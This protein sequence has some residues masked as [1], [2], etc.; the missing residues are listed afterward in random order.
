MK[1]SGIG[2]APTVCFPFVGS[3]VGGSHMSSLLLIEGLLARGVRVEVV[4]ET[5]GALTEL[6]E[7]RAVDYRLLDLDL[8]RASGITR[9]IARMGTAV[10]AMRSFLRDR[11]ISVVHTNDGQIHQRWGL[12]AR[13]VGS[14]WVLHH[15]APHL[16]PAMARLARGSSSLLTVSHYCRAQLPAPLARR[17]VVIDNP[18]DP[19][20]P[21]GLPNTR[22]AVTDLFDADAGTP[23][24]GYI[25][26]LRQPRKRPATF[27]DIAGHLTHDFD[28]RAVFPL[29]GPIRT[30]LAA[31][32]DQRR[33]KWAIEDRCRLLGSQHPVEPWMAAL[34]VMVIPSVNE[35]F[36]RTLV[37]AA[38]LGVPV[39][40]TEDGGN[41]EIIEHG[42][43]GFLVPPDDLSSFAR[44]IDELL[45]DDELR[46]RMGET[47]RARALERFSISSHL[48]AVM[49]VYGEVVS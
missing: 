44:H 41:G 38:M 8:P 46:A 5:S 30:A 33:A 48:D 40:A 42:T 1:A 14:S 17:A 45:G 36:G 39:V 23:V 31:Q 12:A 6:L 25:S 3:T 11:K 15:R 16:T 32:V 13:S 47:A 9:K 24:V 10:P 35:P 28:R 49:R 29:V 43:S 26:N 7:E 37:E 2:V 34:D 20:D 19:L 4:T 27:V 18:F 22:S 21:S